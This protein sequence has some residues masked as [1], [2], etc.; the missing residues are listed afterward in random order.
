MTTLRLHDGESLV[1]AFERVTRERDEARA[2]CE[3][4][5]WPG[6]WPTYSPL[7]A[8]VKR[9]Q[10]LLADVRRT[11]T[12]HT[13]QPLAWDLQELLTRLDAALKEGA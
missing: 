1:D 13:D 12:N 10:A 4:R 3:E 11:L 2:Q 9:L 7:V 5:Y 8:E 6:M